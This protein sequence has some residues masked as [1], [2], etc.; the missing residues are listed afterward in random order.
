M[1]GMEGKLQS[2]EKVNYDFYSRVLLIEDNKGDA[3]LVELL[4]DDAE[5]FECEIFNT[6]TLEGGIEAYAKEEFD[7][8][9]LDLSLPDSQGFETLETFMARFPEAN[10][11]VLTGMSNKQLGIDA[12]RAGAQDYLV[13]GGFDSDWLT[14]ALR[15]SIERSRSVKRLGEAQRLAKVGHWEYH[16]LSNEFNASDEVYRIL[17]YPPRCAAFNAS[18]VGD[19]GSFLDFTK[20]IREN[21]LKYGRHK[22]DFVVNRPDGSEVT[23]YTDTSL[24]RNLKGEA[25]SLGGI[26]QDVTSRKIREQLEKDRDLAIQS[27]KI[28]EN[29]LARVSHEMRTPMNAILGMSNL[30]QKTTLSEEQSSMVGM[31]CQNSAHLLNIINDILDSSSIQTGKF[32]LHDEPFNLRE[33]L[34][35]L[36]SVIE[37][38]QQEK[39]VSFEM[40]IDDGIPEMVNGD[41][42][43]LNQILVNLV[44]NAFKFTEKGTVK[45]RVVLLEALPDKSYIKFMVEDTGIGIPEDQVS[46][47]FEPFSR[48]D[49]KEKNYEGTGLGLS[50][51]YNLVAMMEGSMGVASTLGEG[52]TFF[53]EIPLGKVDPR[54]IKTKQ[55][56]NEVASLSKDIPYRIL[57]VE[58]NKMNQLV[59]QKTIEREYPNIT[60]EVANHGGLALERLLQDGP[61]FHLILM[62]LQ[63]PVMDGYETTQ[64]IRKEMPKH[65][66]DL[67]ILAMTA[68]AQI[69]Q[70]DKFLKH[71][72]DDFVLKPFQ[73]QQLF[74]KLAQH[75]NNTN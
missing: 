42:S 59:A 16:I 15:Y 35:N 57:L 11:I 54:E 46:E 34:A 3:R 25:I 49:N 29:L 47:V 32:R 6:V 53:F 55:E 36:R 31:V 7:A 71:Q 67:P 27:A 30:L 69:A 66:A 20:Q 63:M 72:M 10:V 61:A 44:G 37:H 52:S 8:I 65:I 45:V 58:D 74:S 26:I 51:A 39:K 18:F 9:L 1:E 43:R 33:L 12:V 22:S 48:I 75:I 17:G 21:T 41:A 23:I 68:D 2:R 14:K 28:K 13:K 73:P 4:L 24:T 5:G 19:D 40:C 60:V 62:D 56:A 50:I 38:K 64:K 70:A